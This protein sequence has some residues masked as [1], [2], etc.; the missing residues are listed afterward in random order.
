MN[1]YMKSIKAYPKDAEA[2]IGLGMLHFNKKAYD[3]ALNY[4]TKAAEL[5]AGEKNPENL[6]IYKLI[7]ELYRRK[8]R[9]SKV[10]KKKVE[11]YTLA[12]NAYDQ[13]LSL[14]KDDKEA[15]KRWNELAQARTALKIKMMKKTP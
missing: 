10:N 4:L 1:L 15:K 11:L 5:S 6:E 8:G 12:L 14:K 9:L 3:K 2:L 13:A 7:G